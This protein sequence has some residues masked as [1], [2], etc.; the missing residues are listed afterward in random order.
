MFVQDL[1]Q[2]FERIMGCRAA[3]LLRW[4]PRALPGADLEIA[5]DL[6]AGRCRASFADGQLLIEWRLLAPR[7]IA[8]LSMEQLWVRFSYSGF[9]E[10]R[11]Q[12]VQS[13]FDLATQRGGG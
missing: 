3:E 13:H 10:A 12:K 2:P 11:R 7:R 6:A 9:G 4:L 1:A 5:S 8:L